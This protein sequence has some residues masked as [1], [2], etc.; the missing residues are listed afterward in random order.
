ME[1]GVGK[2]QSSPAATPSARGARIALDY[3]KTERQVMGQQAVLRAGL[4]QRYLRMSHRQ[5]VQIMDMVGERIVEVLGDASPEQMQQHV[6]VLG[7]V[8]I[9]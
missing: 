6:C 9:P 2:A 7:V 3:G 4:F 8:F 5:L 1:A